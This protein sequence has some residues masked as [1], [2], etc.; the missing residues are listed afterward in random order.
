MI[1]YLGSF[2][3]GGQTERLY[4]SKKQKDTPGT[5]LP[6]SLCGW[7]VP[8]KERGYFEVPLSLCVIRSTHRLCWGSWLRSFGCG[9]P[10]PCTPPAPGCAP[11][12]AGCTPSAASRSRSPGSGALRQRVL[13]KSCIARQACLEMNPTVTYRNQG[14]D[15]LVIEVGLS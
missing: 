14:L 9:C 11:C 5:P 7:S 1:C 2:P 8:T 15:G 4:T 13:L 3:G 12:C 10:L 6:I